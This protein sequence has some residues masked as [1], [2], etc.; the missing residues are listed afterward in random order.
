MTGNKE[1]KMAQKP[2]QKP[3][4]AP[5]PPADINHPKPIVR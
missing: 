1:F 2:P 4:P 5:K 3:Q